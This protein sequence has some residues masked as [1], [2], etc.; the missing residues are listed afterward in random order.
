MYCVEHSR[1]FREQASQPSQPAAVST[2]TM[3]SSES[4]SKSEAAIAAK[5]SV[6][7]TPRRSPGKK[8]TTISVLSPPRRLA[9]RIE[10]VV[11]DSSESE[12]ERRPLTNDEKSLLEDKKKAT[13]E[14]R[15]RAR[16]R[17]IKL[18]TEETNRFVE[19]TESRKR[20][21]SDHS[22]ANTIKR[23]KQSKEKAAEGG[24]VHVYEEVKDN[25]TQ[26]W[27]LCR[28]PYTGEVMIQCD[29][30]DE[31]YHLECVGLSGPIPEQYRCLKCVARRAPLRAFKD[32]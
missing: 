23:Q 12:T 22:V 1:Q 15:E 6:E 25:D 32:G 28:K 17:E 9:E 18:L 29:I 24:A 16:H 21:R 11:S 19:A 2:A 31:W 14:Q 8:T 4:R 26:V 7:S 27:C 30:C 10:V 3:S 20:R 13:R 5:P